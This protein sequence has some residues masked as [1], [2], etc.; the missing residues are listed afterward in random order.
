M[1]TSSGGIPR[2]RPFA[3]PALLQQGFRPFFLGAG[4]WSAT[5]LALWLGGLVGAVGLPNSLDWPVWHGHEMVFGFAGAAVAGF[6]LT[7]IPNWTGRLPLQGAPLAVLMSSWVAGRA[8]MLGADL[9]GPLA[10][11]VL[12]LTFLILLLLAVT[13]EIIAGR[14]WRN[15]P[16][17]GALTTFTAANLLVHL[18]AIAV[19]DTA[20]AGLRLGVATS[21]MLISLVGG[22]IIPSFTR[23][24]LVKRGET[25][26]PASSG[27][28]DKAALLVCGAALAAWVAD[29]G[30]W[31][32]G[33]LLLAAATIGAVRL[34][35]WRGHLTAREP[36]LWVLH[37]GHGWLVV[38]LALLGIGQI[39]PIVPETAGLHALTAGAIGTMILGVMTRAS[40]GHTGRALSAGPATTAIYVLVTLAA[41]LRIAATF[42]E[43]RYLAILVI[44][45][46]VWIGAFLL[47]V[48]V[49][50]PLLST[51]RSPREITTS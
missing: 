33:I 34:A 21:L 40:L 39:R 19:A 9:I 18:E 50:A 23:N 14:N 15:L 5:A 4:I 16:M 31:T 43:M 11:A 7:A 32:T 10:T 36:L 46:V 51:S 25:R 22:R 29:I 6:L 12:D 8:A 1:R 30:H 48:A 49:Y 42:A 28:V 3:G 13:R 45:A 37:L 44:S 35:R 24:W 41:V 17:A 26:L 38:G 20:A 2:Y 47:F 27:P